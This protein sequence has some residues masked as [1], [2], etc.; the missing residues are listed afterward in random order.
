[1]FR[2]FLSTT[3]EDPQ[4]IVIFDK[5]IIKKITK[6]LRL[7]V[8]DSLFLFDNTGEEYEVAISEFKDK[9][10]FCR[11]IRRMEIDRELPIEIVLYQSL[12]KKDKFEW[13]CQ[14]V[15]E[16]GIKKIVPIITEFCVVNELNQNKISRYKKIIEEAMIQ[17]GGKIPPIFETVIK[18]EEAVRKLNPRD[19]NLIF[20]EQ[21]KNNN[22]LEILRSHGNKVINIFV[23][24]E[25]G[26]SPFE[27]DLARQ[28]SL[29]QVSLGKRI[30]RAETAGIVACGTISQL[31][32]D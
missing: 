8:G 14:K 12:L 30:L 26:F 22:L 10:F 29:I 3:I 18:F 17:S 9:K 31:F 32:V 1:M 20:H 2:F 11:L 28:N 24:P 16:I 4:N 13:V 5:A 15:T 25:G 21:E 6:V 23:G 19:L 7:N 27:I